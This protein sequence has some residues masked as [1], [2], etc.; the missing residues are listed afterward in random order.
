MGKG[1]KFQEAIGSINVHQIK[2][3]LLAL[4]AVNATIND[5]GYQHVTGRFKSIRMLLNKLA[6]CSVASHSKNC[7]V[8]K[9]NV[10]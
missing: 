7:G 2:S 6:G 8:I 1:T 5:Q 3:K 9:K 10:T 4:G